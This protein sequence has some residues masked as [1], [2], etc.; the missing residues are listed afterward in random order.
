MIAWQKLKKHEIELTLQIA[1]RFDKLLI[2][3]IEVVDIVMTLQKCHLCTPLNLPLLLSYDDLSF[4]R[5]I[6][7]IY[8]NTNQ[9]TGKLE[10]NYT[11]CSKVI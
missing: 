9:Q 11:P 7:G 8:Y 5:E 4:S 10:N 3:S 6:V 2:L 1:E